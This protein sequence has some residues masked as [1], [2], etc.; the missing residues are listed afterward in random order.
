[1]GSDMGCFVIAEAGVNHNGSVEMARNLIEAAALAGADAVKFQ[2]FRADRLVARGAPKAA[3]Q[4]RA[5]GSGESQ[6]E[7][8]RN[9]ELDDA[10]WDP[11]FSHAAR[12]GIALLATP[13]DSGSLSML[14]EKHGMRTVK[15]SSGDI[16]DAPFL[17]EIARAAKTVILSTGMS[18]LADI[19]AALGVLAFGFCQ[20]ADVMPSRRGFEEAFSSEA[21]QGALAARVTLL[22][23]TTEYPAPLREVNLRAMDTLVAAFGLKVGYSDHTVGTHV[24][25]AAAARG[26]CTVEKHFTLDRDLPGPDHKASLEPDELKTMISAIRD[27]ANALGDGIKRPTPSEWKNRD[28]ARKS[29]V[30]ARDLAVGEKIVA[31]CKRPGTG[32]SPFEYWRLSESTAMRNYRADEALDG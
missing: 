23:C 3:Y 12:C 31:T 1:M 27:V 29:L 32:V 22:H 18:T 26:A 15:V 4:R 10:D 11:L 19:E 13:F 24:S 7:M 16:T 9:L 28:V 30:A 20:Q 21:G 8:L 5:T 6:L 14:V 17:L 25:I 2:A